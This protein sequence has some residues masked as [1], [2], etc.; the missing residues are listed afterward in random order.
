[1]IESIS[2]H[3]TSRTGDGDANGDVDA[4]YR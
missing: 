3:L 1:M 2:A 4:R